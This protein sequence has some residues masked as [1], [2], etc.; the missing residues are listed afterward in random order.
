MMVADP[1]PAMPS[2]SVTWLYLGRR[3][4]DADAVKVRVRGLERARLNGEGAE[5]QAWPGPGAVSR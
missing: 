2:R 5:R 3:M 1:P 4:S